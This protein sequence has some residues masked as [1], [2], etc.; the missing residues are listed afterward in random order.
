MG[1][2][3]TTDVITDTEYHVRPKDSFLYAREIT[4]PFGVIDQVIVWCKTELQ[5][6]W[7]WHLVDTSSDQR[8]GRYVFYF[9]SERDLCAFVM[10][11]A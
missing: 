11:W 2:I 7:R 4:K 6:E 8:P 10:Q 1:Q 9:D 3:I 5:G